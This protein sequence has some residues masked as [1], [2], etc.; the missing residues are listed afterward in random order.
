MKQRV[1]SSILL[2]A[3][4]GLVLCGC[5][6][7][8]SGSKGSSATGYEQV[9]AAIK[10]L[11]GKQRTAKLVSLAQ[12]EGGKLTFYTSVSS[13]AADAFASGFNDAYGIEVAV[14]RSNTEDVVERLTQEAAANYHGADVAGLDG[15]SLY[16]LN[17]KSLLVDYKADGLPQL[18]P[19]A[20]RDGWTIS[21]FAP[22]AVSWN[23]KLV[24]AGEQPR[25]LED[26]ANPRWRG[27]LALESSDFEWYGTVRDYWVT[28]GGKSEAEAD[29]LFEQIGRNAV[30]MRGHSLMTQLLAAGEFDVAASTFASKVDELRK[31]G[32]PVSR[33][34]AVEPVIVVTNGMALVRGSHHP[35]AAALFLEW[36][37]GDGQKSIQELGREPARRDLTTTGGVRTVWEDNAKLVR[38][39]KKWAADYE[40]VLSHGKVRPDD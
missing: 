2:L 5:G 8:S 29:R 10:G 22:F 26:L 4:L 7:S 3:L 40:R 13:E 6:G 30:A 39:Q 32:A 21:E 12:A 31:D 1:R 27:K 17:R 14:Y 35:A 28:Q 19:G 18:V 9:F 25:T 23:T 24:H 33:T 16:N 38:N 11:H 15:L 20:H 36:V 34:P 37:L